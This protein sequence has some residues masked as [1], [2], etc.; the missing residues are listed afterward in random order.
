[1][2]LNNTDGE[3]EDRLSGIIPQIELISNV[4]MNKDIS[5]HP[6]SSWHIISGPLL[7]FTQM[8]DAPII[9][10]LRE[11][12]RR[13]AE[14]VNPIFFPGSAQGQSPPVL[15]LGCSDSRVPE[16]VVLG[17]R[18]G[19]IFVH[20]NI[21]NQFNLRDDSAQSVL[22]FSVGV[23][24]VQHV[25]V[26]GHTQC[27]ACKASLDI[28]NQNPVADTPINRFLAELIEI[29][30][31]INALGKPKPEAVQALVEASVRHQ[32][33]NVARSPAVQAAWKEKRQLYVHGWVY[34]LE[35]GLVRDLGVTEGPPNPC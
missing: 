11:S 32:V 3:I 14:S 22:D 35:T 10:A 16:S 34:S 24:K 21:G 1:L 8:S 9:K 30:R 33:K 13:W 17:A 26:V 20:R 29:A 4:A 25:I 19:D 18:P 31:K 27:G 23:V 7:S 2:D 12:N 28:A 15:W 6:Q 5:P